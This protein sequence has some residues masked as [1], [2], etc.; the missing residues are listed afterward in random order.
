MPTMPAGP[1]ET[2]LGLKL[3]LEAFRQTPSGSIS[4]GAWWLAFDV[5]EDV[6]LDERSKKALKA[7]FADSQIRR[8]IGRLVDAGYRLGREHAGTIRRQY[9]WC[10]EHFGACDWIDG[11]GD[12][13]TVSWCGGDGHATVCLWTSEERAR[14]RLH[15][16][17][18][19]GCGSNCVRAHEGYFLQTGEMLR[20]EGSGW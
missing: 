17:Q 9:Q 20:P 4:R 13:A 3:D 18:E 12:Y 6:E 11:V 5:L 8:A 19:A 14:A 16:L 7:L 2:R 1:S 10:L 15:A